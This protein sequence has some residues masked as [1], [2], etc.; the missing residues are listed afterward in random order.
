[1]LGNEWTNSY[2]FQFGY[3]ESF[4]NHIYLLCSPF[5]FSLHLGNLTY[6]SFTASSSKTVRFSKLIKNTFE[7]KS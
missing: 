6:V 3:I 7:I 1:M 5:T 2:Y 4:D